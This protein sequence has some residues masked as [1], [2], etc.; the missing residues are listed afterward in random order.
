[1]SG[2]VTSITEE[3]ARRLWR[4]W[5]DARDAAQK[6]PGVEQWRAAVAAWD[7]F[8]AEFDKLGKAG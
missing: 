2:A 8:K 1:M 4:A 5:N 3:R 7:A 6:R